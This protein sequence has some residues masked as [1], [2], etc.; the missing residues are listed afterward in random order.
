MSRLDGAWR[1]RILKKADNDLAW[2]RKHKK[3]YYLKCFDF[4]REIVKEPRRGT[5]KP[6]KLKYFKQKVWSRRVSPEDRLVY[7]IYTEA[8]E[9]DIVSCKSHYDGVV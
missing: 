2:F 1:T 5:G 3:A 7:V 8:H 4:I 9:V 6:E